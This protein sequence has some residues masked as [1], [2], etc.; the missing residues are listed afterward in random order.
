[1]DRAERDVQ[2]LIMLG[3]LTAQPADEST[4]FAPRRN[5]NTLHSTPRFPRELSLEESPSLAARPAPLSG[6]FRVLP[7]LRVKGREFLG[8]ELVKLP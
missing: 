5:A 7:G 1:M 4:S 2:H 8:V 3:V 6:P